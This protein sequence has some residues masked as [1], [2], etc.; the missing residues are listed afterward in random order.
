VVVLVGVGVL[1]G[2][3]V[4]VGVA[5]AVGVSVDVAVGVAV[6]VLVGVFV[7]VLVA[8]VVAVGVAVDVGVNE[9]VGVSVGVLVGVLVGVAVAV[10]VGVEVLVGVSVGILVGV[11]VAVPVAIRLMAPIHVPHVAV[12]MFAGEAGSRPVLTPA[13]PA[14]RGAAPTLVDSRECHIAISASPMIA[15][16]VLIVISFRGNLVARF[17]AKMANTWAINPF[18]KL[19]TSGAGDRS[20]KH[21]SKIG[22]VV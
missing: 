21:C 14:S 16:F 17:S 4:A 12:D 7:G 1:V 3:M 22:K 6:A 8:V 15:L 20:E 19:R 13:S 5:V 9:L 11:T 10:D 18:D 2:V